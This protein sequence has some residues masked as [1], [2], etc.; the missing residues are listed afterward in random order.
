LPISRAVVF[1]IHSY[2]VRREDL[3]PEQTVALMEHPLNHTIQA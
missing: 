1:S 3:T 2:V